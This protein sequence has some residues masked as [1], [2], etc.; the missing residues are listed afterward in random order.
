MVA[1]TINVTTI[2]PVTR[3]QKRKGNPVKHNLGDVVLVDCNV[4]G[5]DIGTPTEPKFALRTL[6]KATVLPAYDALTAVGGPAEGAT[7]VHQ[8]D[9][10]PPH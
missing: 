5:S 6:W 4:R 10:A 3:K 2:D 1:R 9:N 8:E 7:I